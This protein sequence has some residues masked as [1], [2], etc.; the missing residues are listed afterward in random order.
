MEL[1]GLEPA[2]SWCDLGGLRPEIPLVTRFLGLVFA[3]LNI[4]PNTL[5]SV[6]Q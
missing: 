2:T 5:R 4:F 6:L 3:S 1:G